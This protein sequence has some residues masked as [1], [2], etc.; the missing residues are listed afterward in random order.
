MVSHRSG[1]TEDTFIA[2]LVVGLCTGQ[3]HDMHYTTKKHGHFTA[4]TNVQCSLMSC[5]ATL[6]HLHLWSDQDRRPLQIRAFGKVQP[7]DEVSNDIIRFTN[8]VKGQSVC[9]KPSSVCLCSTGSRKSSVTRP[10]LR[11]K[12]SVTQNSKPSKF[13]H[14]YCSITNVLFWNEKWIKKVKEMECLCIYS[15]EHP[16][17]REPV[18]LH[19]QSL[20]EWF[21]SVP[22]NWCCWRQRAEG[23][24][25]FGS[26]CECCLETIIRPKAFQRDIQKTNPFVCVSY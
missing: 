14:Q 4:N 11:A 21:S 13:L 15:H 10:S 18:L 5:S 16:E 25:G 22:L 20:N 12:T 8:Q 6:T 3:V 23:T 2:D 7:A 19:V 26:R 9:A 17:L 1:E 24:G